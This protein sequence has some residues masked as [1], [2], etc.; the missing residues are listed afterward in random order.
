[1]DFFRTSEK[2]I[3]TI[4]I[5][6]RQW[7]I[8]T[9]AATVLTIIVI[10]SVIA[11]VLPK[12]DPENEDPVP[13]ET[14]E[15]YLCLDSNGKPSHL[16]YG[17]WMYYPPDK[18]SEYSARWAKKHGWQFVF[19]STY[20]GNEKRKLEFKENSKAFKKY[21]IAFH[22]MTLESQEYHIYPETAKQEVQDILDYAESENLTIAGIHTDYEP[23]ALAEWKTN[24]DKLF[25]QYKQ[26]AADVRRIV[27]TKKNL[28]Y[29]AA[30]PKFPKLSKEGK[31]TDGRGYDL[32]NSNM[33]DLAV[34]ML[35]DGLG[36]TAADIIKF[37]RM[38]LDD[39]VST[40]TGIKYSEHE[41]DFDNV[42][43]QVRNTFTTEVGTK[44]IYYGV[45]VYV[46]H[47]YSDWGSE[48]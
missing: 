25:Q 34:P 15:P 10:V 43:D 8:I 3:S 26:I 48:I 41:A 18:D 38:Y 22:A 23:H 47:E 40:V 39:N 24:P 2:D 31:I 28:L 4:P 19:F 1:M 20:V 33:F 46:N 32:V 11:I 29:S 36:D 27:K 30:L 45:S 12:K 6:K 42:V 37:A 13:P 14:D 17:G 16:C 7:F 21:G 35:Y 44:D 9:T 5:Y